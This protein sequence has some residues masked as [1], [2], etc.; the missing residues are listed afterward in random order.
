MTLV[1]TIHMSIFGLDITGFVTVLK[2]IGFIVSLG[3]GVGIV[4]VFLNNKD[5]DEKRAQKFKEHFHI[6]P[7]KEDPRIER[8]NDITKHFKSHSEV[9]WRMAIIDADTMLEDLITS[10]GYQGQTFGEKLKSMQRSGLPW[11]QSAWDVHLLRNKI[12]HEGT[13]YHI[14]E[15]EVYW[16]FQTFERI[17]YESGYFS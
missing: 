9:E 17:F 8:W 13:A 11:L 16:A 4:I 15:R 12:A 2:I 3:F 14:T 7:K 1:Y 6:H 5:L 10:M